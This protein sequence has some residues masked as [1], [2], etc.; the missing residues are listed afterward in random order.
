MVEPARP[1]PRPRRQRLA[2]GRALPLPRRELVLQ[3]LERGYACRGDIVCAFSAG[4]ARE[5]TYVGGGKQ[6]ITLLPGPYT[7]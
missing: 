3:D 6:N 2:L 5:P 4:G 7:V 1:S